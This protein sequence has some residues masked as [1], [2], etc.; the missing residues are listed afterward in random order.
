MRGISSA[1]VYGTKGAIADGAGVKILL[2]A[3]NFAYVGSGADFT[4]DPSLAVPANEVTET[5]GGRIFYSATNQNG[6]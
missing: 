1:N 4:N 2:T 3:H 6:D 5:N